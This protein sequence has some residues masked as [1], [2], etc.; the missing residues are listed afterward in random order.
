MQNLWICRPLHPPSITFQIIF[1]G[2]DKPG[3]AVKE[4]AEY[5]IKVVRKNC[6]SSS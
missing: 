3:K 2:S 1:L 4:N 5:L 6:F